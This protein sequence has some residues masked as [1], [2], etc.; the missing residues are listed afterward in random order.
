MLM[1]FPEKLLLTQPESAA[2]LNISERKFWE[3]VNDGKIPKLKV[4]R[5]VRFDVRDLM[6][7][8]DSLKQLPPKG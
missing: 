8:A 2:F 7:Y 4:G 1:Q 6:A 3:I 5:S